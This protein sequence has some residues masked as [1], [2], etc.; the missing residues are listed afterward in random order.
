MQI[1][2][3][4]LSN[5]LKF[6][7]RNGKITIRITVED[8]QLATGNRPINSEKDITL[9]SLEHSEEVLSKSLGKQSIDVVKVGQSRWLSF[10]ISVIDTGVGIAKENI[11]KLFV[12]FGKLNE[13]S[14]RNSQGT[15]LGLSISKKLIE[16]MG[17]SVD[18]QS[19]L[20]IGSEFTINMK[21][22][23]KVMQTSYLF[24]QNN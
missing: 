24:Q 8:H 12:D 9:K 3:N 5:S 2:L 18:V 11:P 7:N 22:Q 17:G 14:K 23:C 10:K 4:F 15:G 16:K 21:T 20:G 1:L 13:H 19:I 6:T